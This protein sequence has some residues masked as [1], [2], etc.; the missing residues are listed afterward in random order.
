M[1]SFKESNVSKLAKLTTHNFF[2]PLQTIIPWA[3]NLYT[4]TLIERTRARY[5]DDFL[6]FWMLGGCSGGGMGFIFK[7][8]SKREA[9]DGI[10]EIMLKTKREMEHALPFAMDPVVYDF[11]INNHGTVSEFC[12][13]APKLLEK[14]QDGSEKREATDNQVILDDIL[15]DL[16]FDS[17]EHENQRMR[18]KNGEIGL[19]Q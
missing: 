16:G 14:Q 10:Q 17:K 9:L 7:P 19:K 8:E 2:E 18:Y 12:E 5:G 11:S 3:S 6:G 15:S 13:A 4:E 1:D